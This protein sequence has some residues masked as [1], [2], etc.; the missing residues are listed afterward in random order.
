MTGDEIADCYRGY[1]ACLNNR[2]WAELERFVHKEVH[3]NGQFVGLDGYRQMLDGDVRAIPDLQFNIG[4]LIVEPP[5]VAAQLRFDCTPT[6]ELFGLAVNGK[7]V[8]FTENVFYEFLE[9]K[10]RNVWSVID[11]KAVADQL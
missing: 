5:H 8:V 9:G 4:L 10:I 6:G 3:Y 11:K 1:I 7:R 2:R